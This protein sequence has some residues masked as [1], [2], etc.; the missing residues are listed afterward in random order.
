MTHP[1]KVLPKVLL[2]DAVT[3]LVTGLAL[4]SLAGWLAE[5]LGL[6]GT[7]LR[8]AGL[9]LLPFAM[10]LVHAARR[11]EPARLELW[12]IVVLNGG[13]V[14]DS[15]LLLLTDWV[16]PTLLGQAFVIG[17]ACIVALLTELQYAG[18]QA[19]AETRATLPASR[20]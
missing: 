20:G 10:L 14:L 12:T 16:Q 3:C 13:W 18:M 19:L 8:Y 11:A 7:L 4:A 1:S 2:I 15:V 17:Q 5:P 9:S 6:P